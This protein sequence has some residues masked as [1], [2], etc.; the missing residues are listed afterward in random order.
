MRLACVFVVCLVLA[1]LWSPRALAADQKEIARLI[2]RLASSDFQARE[3]ATKRLTEIGEPALGALE[4]AKTGDDPEVR[5]RAEDIITVIEIK[6]NP[7]LILRGHTS[8]VRC[9]CVSADGTRV[10]TGS[11]DRT[12]KLWDSH[13]GECLQ[14]FKGHTDCVNSAALSPDGQRVLSGSEDWTVRLWDART[15]KELAKMTVAKLGGS[16]PPVAFGPEGQPIFSGGDGT[17]HSWDLN[18]NREAG[19]FT[20]PIAAPNVWVAPDGKRRL[21]A[22][23][24]NENV[25]I[26][27]AETGQELSRIST[28]VACC[29]AFSPDGKR[30]VTGGYTDMIMRVWDIATSKELCTYERHVDGVTCVRYFPNGKRIISTSYDGTAHIWRAPTAED[31]LPDSEG[32]SP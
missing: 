4:H 7:E 10:L 6:L 29:V 30:L 23:A 16:H 3:A 9:M 12:L 18:T 27:D 31:I 8:S 5:T 13:S 19:V 15:G 2:K 20:G 17:M 26:L 21:S 25:R 32:Q 1:P 14:V 28:P 11:G 24:D 22:P